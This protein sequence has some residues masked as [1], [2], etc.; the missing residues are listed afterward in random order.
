MDYQ[1]H[2]EGNRQ[3]RKPCWMHL[4]DSL[5]PRYTWEPSLAHHCQPSAHCP[6][7]NSC[8]AGIACFLFKATAIRLYTFIC[9]IV[10]LETAVY[11]GIIVNS[12]EVQQQNVHDCWLSGGDCYLIWNIPLYYMFLFYQTWTVS[13]KRS[14][15]S[16]RRPY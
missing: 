12:W 4:V 15:D 11:A 9:D 16:Y 6:V 8:S 3:D 2:R 13:A 14:R 1:Q 5:M 7:I 10:T